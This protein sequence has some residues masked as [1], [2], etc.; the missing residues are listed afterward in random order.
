MFIDTHAHFDLVMEDGSVTETQIIESMKT[1]GI[2][3]AVQVS[4]DV[5]SSEWSRA[6]AMRHS[7]EGILFTIGI[8]PSSAADDPDLR[9]LS[10]L[11]DTII[12]S[13][14]SKLLVGIGECGLDYYRMRQKREVQ[15]NSF[16]FQIDLAN[17]CGLPVIVHS[18]DAMEDTLEI[19]RKE[20]RNPGI[21]HCF[22]GDKN[23]AQKVLDL[24]M[25]ISFAG[26]LTYR[27]AA[28]LHES[29]RYIPLNR[30][31]VETDAPFLTPVPLRGKKNR[32]EHVIHTYRYLSELRKEPLDL[33]AS[34]IRDNFREI[35][36]NAV[37][38]LQV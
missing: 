37:K 9:H 35:A 12:H 2:G 26:N 28:D 31:L 13:G 20:S 6:F 29:A 36:G 30:L 3:T 1:N 24:G 5:S 10:A 25:Y 17:R 19:L 34:T 11:A 22:P 7:G 18:R 4:I 32:T 38:N 33:I 27:A 21:M 23:A 16:I 15:M 14:D 8:H